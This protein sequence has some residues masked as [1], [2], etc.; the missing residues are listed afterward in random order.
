M[1]YPVNFFNK[2]SKQLTLD[3]I[4]Y[5]TGIELDIDEVI[6]GEPEWV[7][8][9]VSNDDDTNTFIPIVFLD[10]KDIRFNGRSG[11]LYRRARFT[12]ANIE[13]LGSFTKYPT[14]L[15]EMLPAINAKFGTNVV[16]S[17]VIDRTYNAPVDFVTLE[18]SPTSKNF[19]GTGKLFVVERLLKDPVLDG[20]WEYVA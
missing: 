16:A 20:F 5:S 18:A 14:T 3:L 12:E 8:T 7:D 19:F 1:E 13:D 6:L 11:V 9:V 2:S 17:D 4:L 15:V 10:G